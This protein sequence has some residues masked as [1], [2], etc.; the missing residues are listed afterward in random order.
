MLC[1]SIVSVRLSDSHKPVLCRKGWTDRA[2]HWHNCFLSPI[3]HCF[4][5]TFCGICENVGTSSHRNC[6]PN[7]GP[8]EFRYC[9]STVYVASKNHRRLSSLTKLATIDSRAVT[10]LPRLFTPVAPPEGRRKLSP[11][12]VDVQKLCNMCVLSLSWNFFV[13]HDT[14]PYR[15]IPHFPLLTKSWRRHWFTH[16]AHSCYTSVDRNALTPWLRSVVD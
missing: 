15:P 1:T 4:V 14:T 12:W 11:L 6:V 8:R 7:S 2:G 13:S 10:E 9:K 5:R 3:L 16:R